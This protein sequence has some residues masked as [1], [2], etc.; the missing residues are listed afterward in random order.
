MRQTNTKGSTDGQERHSFVATRNTTYRRKPREAVTVNAIA[1]QSD[2]DRLR[3]AAD[4]G[5]ITDVTLHV[6]KRGDVRMVTYY[7]K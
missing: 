7:R 1:S 5:D 3:D 2:L 4:A 6:T